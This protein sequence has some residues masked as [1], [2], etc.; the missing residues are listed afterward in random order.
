[1][2]IPASG[3]QKGRPISFKIYRSATGEVIDA[4]ATFLYGDGS[5]GDLNFTH[6][7]LEATLYEEQTLNLAG[8]RFNLISLPVE[9]TNS[10]AT[11][12]FGSI[13]DLLIAQDDLGSAFIPEYNVNSIG[14]YDFSRAYHIFRSGDDT[15]S[16]PLTGRRVVKAE[17]PVTVYGGR[18][19]NIPNLYRHPVNVEDAF[20]DIADRI[21]ILQDDAGGAWIPGLGVNSIGA[22]VPGKGYQL[23]LSGATD[24]TIVFEDLPEYIEMGKKG[25]TT[26]AP[27]HYTGVVETGLPYQVVITGWH[28]DVAD[29][30]REVALWSGDRLVGAAVADDLP[31]LITAW[32]AD[33]EH[34]LPGFTAG[35]VIRATGWYGDDSSETDLYL[36]QEDGSEAQYGTGAYAAL[37]GSVSATVGAEVNLPTDYDLGSNY[38]NPF[39]SRTTVQY[40]LPAAQDVRIDV[41]NVV[42]QRVATLVDEVQPAGRH[43]VEWDGSALS[44]GSLTNGVYFLRMEAGSF[45][46]TRKVVF[47][48]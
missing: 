44:G 42:G 32:E 24:T 30:L 4:D 3:Y 37:T 7:Q 8:N 2:I 39:S 33:S 17:R 22:T 43:T 10:S 19:N 29:G 31:V 34:N 26:S 48:K 41:Y 14:D 35:E 15:L 18:F 9:P 6:V 1:M 36:L 16:Y 20:A 21:D 5:F 12:V 45:R 11:S 27:E 38:P 25:S 23:F 40:S 46:A 28:D 13:N 47:L